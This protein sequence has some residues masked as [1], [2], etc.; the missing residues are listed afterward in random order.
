MKTITKI[1]VMS[2]QLA[3]FG[4]FGRELTVDK[5]E[6]TLD[7][8]EDVQIVDEFL[9]EYLLTTEGGDFLTATKEQMVTWFGADHD[10][11]EEE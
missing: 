6:I 4:E 2:D 5:K 1:K 9:G 3:T 7:V 10:D 8:G 11:V